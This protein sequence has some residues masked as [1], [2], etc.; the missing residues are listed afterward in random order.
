MYGRCHFQAV[1]GRTLSRIIAAVAVLSIGLFTLSTTNAATLNVVGGQLVGASG[2]DVDG[3]L[4]N[5]QFVDGSCVSVFYGC[6]VSDFD[7]QT[8]AL[9]VLA[10]QALLDQVLLDGPLGL[11]D[12]DPELTA[13]CSDLS[14]CT[15]FIPF[16]RYS[17]LGVAMAYAYNASLGNGVDFAAAGGVTLDGGISTPNYTYARFAVS[18]VPL[19]A[20]F[21]LFLTALGGLGFLE[22]RRR[23]M[24]SA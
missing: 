8:Q 13:G 3:A 21:P 6:E 16:S 11:F 17:T 24:Q 19:P 15:V 18:S 23:R 12:S 10:T 14:V 7:F 2:V 5:V 9:A 22:W 1:G 4:Y 20:A